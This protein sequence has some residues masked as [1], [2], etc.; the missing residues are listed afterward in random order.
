MIFNCERCFQFFTDCYTDVCMLCWS[1]GS[2]VS[3]S[4]VMARGTKLPL[5]LKVFVF[6]VR[7]R[8]PEGS[9]WKME[10]AGCERSVTILPVFFLHPL[11]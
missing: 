7:N 9:G 3:L 10:F 2:L 6:I 8:S 4:R 11:L 5:C 1:G